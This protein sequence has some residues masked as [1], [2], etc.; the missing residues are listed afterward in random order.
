MITRIGILVLETT[1]ITTKLIEEDTEILITLLDN[2]YNDQI[3]RGIT[4][5]IQIITLLETMALTLT[6]EL[7]YRFS[8]RRI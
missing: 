7:I 3:N 1:T 2:N 4:V 6:Q 5:E 8:K